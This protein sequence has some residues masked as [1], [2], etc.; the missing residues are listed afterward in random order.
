[1]SVVASPGLVALVSRSPGETRIALTEAGDLVEIHVFR[2]CRPVGGAVV[3]GVVI[4]HLP[5]CRAALV[6]IGAED[7]GFLPLNSVSGNRLPPEGERLPVQIVH[8]PR[9]G[10]GARL[11]AALSVSGRYL[12]LVPS[13]PGLD[14]SSRVDPAQRERLRVVLSPLLTAEEGVVVRPAACDADE[15]SLVQEFESLRLR[16]RRILSGA[17]DC[18]LPLSV[19]LSGRAVGEVLCDDAGSLLSLRASGFAVR[20]WSGPGSLLSAFGFEDV[21]ERALARRVPLSSGGCLWIEST[22]A[23]TAIDVDSGSADPVAVNACAV[24][25]IARQIRLRALAGMIAVDFVAPPRNARRAKQALALSLSGAVSKD[26]VATTVVGVSGLG[27]VEVRRDRGRVPLADILLSG[28]RDGGLDPLPETSALDALRAALNTLRTA[29]AARVALRVSPVL[30]ALLTGR[31]APAMEE[32]ARKA[33]APVGLEVLPG[34]P[35]SYYEV[36]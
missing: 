21:L 15:D 26:P 29:P 20:L 31:L 33:G 22:K 34:S 27:L 18:P 17:S 6:D 32:A 23:L 11:S 5:G 9:R 28:R 1:M 35:S 8:E 12:A 36:V 24:V 30:H 3:P 2:D 25:E 4:G 10:K 7:P 13:R 19:A 16:Y 14:L